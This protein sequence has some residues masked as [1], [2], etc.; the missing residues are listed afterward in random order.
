MSG[1]AG[2]TLTPLDFEDRLTWR[3]LRLYTFF[4]LLLV[5]L[6][7]TL[8]LAWPRLPP[9]A[10]GYL[11]PALLTAWLAMALAAGFA[12]RLRRPAFR[13][14]VLTTGT[15]DLSA[16][17]AL[18][19]LLG[20]LD[21]GLG[22]LLPIAVFALALL[23]PGRGALFLAALAT[24]GI[25]AL[26]FQ[27]VLAGHPTAATLSRTG[28]LGLATFLSAL[29]GSVLS[30]RIRQ[31]EQLAHR[32]GVDL[33][34]LSRLNAHIVQR[35]E[36]GVL[37]VD[38]KGHIR[39]M[40]DRL[41]HQLALPERLE[42]EHI[43]QL[44]PALARAWEAWRTHPRGGHFERLDEAGR[45]GA[46]FLPLGNRP[47]AGTLILV[48]D[49]TRMEEEAR[50][51]RLAALG[52]LSASIAHEIRNPLSAIGHALQLLSESPRLDA[53]DRHLLAIAVK[54]VQRV[55][56]VIGSV[57]QLSRRQAAQPRTLVLADW[58]NAYV[59]EAEE[60]GLLQPGQA[61]VD[62]D[63]GD[64]RVRADPVHLH[65]IL[66]NLVRNALEHA[67]TE[68]KVRVRLRARRRDGHTAVLDVIDNGA[69]ID[70]ETAERLFEPFFTRRASGTGLGLYLA[71]ELA[72]SDGMQLWY[73]DK[74]CNCFRLEIPAPEGDEREWKPTTG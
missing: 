27:A 3:P 21:S 13:L 17:V 61:R 60:A 20:G 49:R 44:S 69:P 67:V 47:E 58:L 10:D 70:P 5:A 39:L 62:V 26:A 55:N 57:L 51:L 23:V 28:L 73:D 7:F 56:R 2:A 63:P 1:P 65:Q 15:L 45:L 9:G 54:Q 36:A 37:V 42:A 18:T 29:T 38:G 53:E 43:A 11:L 25:F 68:E 40:N 30:R 50:Q 12:A 31:S 16:I 22:I 4:R 59:A 32:Q 19:Y 33:A 64:L 14:Q 34:N 35:L 8:R 72:S 71:R 41:W 6:L 52:R 66:D 74:D 24:F 46:R 48:E